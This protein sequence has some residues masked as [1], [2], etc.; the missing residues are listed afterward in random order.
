[1]SDIKIGD[2]V[3]GI[4]G[5]TRVA[6]I[7]MNI[8]EGHVHIKSPVSGVYA[9]VVNIVPLHKVT[10]LG[11][12]AMKRKAEDEDDGGMSDYMH[13]V[14]TSKKPDAS[15]AAFDAEKKKHISSSDMMKLSKIHQLLHKEET[16]SPLTNKNQEHAVHVAG[17]PVTAYPNSTQAQRVGL[18]LKDML[19]KNTVSVHHMGEEVEQIDETSTGKKLG[20][21]AVRLGKG[22]AATALHVASTPLA[23]LAGF[24]GKNAVRKVG[25]ASLKFHY[26]AYD[27]A[28]KHLGKGIKHLGALEESHSIVDNL[29]ADGKHEEAGAKAFEHGLGRKYGQHFGL[30]STKDKDEAS[31]HKGYDTAEAKSKKKVNEEVK[32]YLS[33]SKKNWDVINHNGKTVFSHKDKHVALSHLKKNYD[34]Y[35]DPKHLAEA[36]KADHPWRKPSAIAKAKARMAKEQPGQLTRTDARAKTPQGNYS[37][38]KSGAY[39]SKTLGEAEQID[40]KNMYHNKPVKMTVHTEK[41]GK[42]YKGTHTVI[43]KKVPTLD[44]PTIQAQTRERAEKSLKAHLKSRGHKVTGIEHLEEAPNY[45]THGSYDRSSND[46]FDRARRGFKSREHEFEAEVEARH[47]AAQV[48]RDSEPHHIYING[49]VWKKDG[50]PVTF[51][52]KKHA[53]AVG[54]SILKKNPKKVVQLLHHS[55]HAKHGDT[56]PTSNS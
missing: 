15:Q 55:F 50:H 14:Q 45:R 28:K 26:K 53:N 42:V 30:R 52:N 9:P 43:V 5:A 25:D 40:E 32:P 17:Q 6:G 21:A 23:G 8:K 47:H 19:G 39:F 51:N 10:K 4:K 33:K 1:M 7:V 54:L 16:K 31:F 13:H 38:G 44:T 46:V 36:P 22:A 37:S 27:A 3:V 35:R 12:G 48:Q 11:E 18:K 20:A 41:D 29:K 24:P 2:K 34:E 56:M 49:R